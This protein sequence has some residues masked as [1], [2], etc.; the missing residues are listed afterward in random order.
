MLRTPR[1][2]LRYNRI[3]APG[4]DSDETSTGSADGDLTLTIAQ[5]GG[6]SPLEGGAQLGRYVVLE[7][8][9]A[10][11]MGEVVRAYDPKLRREVALKRLRTGALD[12]EAEARLLREAQAMAQLSHPN[13]LPVF[14]VEHTDEGVIMAMEFVDGQTLGQWLKTTPPRDELVRHFVAAGRALQAAHGAGLVHRDFKP[15]NVMRGN[16]GRVRVLDFGI[17]RA[18]SA[19]EVSTGGHRAVLEDDEDDSL[20][21]PLTQKGAV[22]GTPAY[23]APEQHMGQPA[24]ARS[25][26]Y[27]FCLALWE[28]LVGRRPFSGTM[29]E[30]V[31]AKRDGPPSLPPRA[32]VPAWLA[33][34]VVRGLQPEPDARWP[35]MAPLLDALSHD[36]VRARRRWAGL[37]AGAVGLVGAGA[38][39]SRVSSEAAPV[40]PDARTGLA[41]VWAQ[42]QRDQVSATLQE[43]DAPY[44][45]PVAAHVLSQIDDYAD[46]WVAMKQDTCEAT[47]IRGEQSAELFDLRV[48]CLQ[49]RHAGLGA[50]VS[51]LA[52]ADSEIVE[53][54]A[55]IVDGLP[56]LAPCADLDGLR[57]AVPPPETAQAAAEVDAIRQELARVDILT[58]AGRHEDA[59]AQLEPLVSRAKAVGYPLIEVEVLGA[60]GWNEDSA[61]HHAEAIKSLR[62]AYGTAVELGADR[63]AAKFAIDLAA[64][65]GLGESKLEPADVWVDAGM[66]L[67]RRTDDQLLYARALNVRG[68]IANRAA[69]YSDAA[70]DLERAIAILARNS[71]TGTMRARALNHLGISLDEL[72]Q[73]AEAQE[74]FREAA[75]LAEQAHGPE[76]PSVLNPLANLAISLSIEGRRGEA[77]PILE[78]VLAARIKLYGPA[79]PRTALSRVNLGWNY[80]DDGLAAESIDHFVTARAAFVEKLGP[81]HANVAMAAEGIGA[82]RMALGQLDAAAEAYEE[83]LAVRREALGPGHAYVAL[84]LRSLASVAKE[85]KDYKGALKTLDEALVLLDGSGDDG[86]RILADVHASRAATLFALERFGPAIASY[87]TALENMTEDV[88]PMKLGKTKFGLARALVASGGDRARARKLAELAHQTFD[89]SRDPERDEALAEIGT[90]LSELD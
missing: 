64:T 76:H 53:Q 24:D 55:K 60:H 33:S 57:A 2:G 54:A 71:G 81:R 19:V 43:S 6:T 11:G 89:A 42:T 47:R 18:T 85:R 28:G 90:F 69:R 36:P 41:D 29:T 80:M 83:S 9:G 3:L 50:V 84:S 48:S 49:R 66:A 7:R 72:E 73:F 32:K 79:H 13:V 22:M 12:P 86:R 20:S 78:R 38:L 34:I 61:G 63:L 40:C 87:E 10:G 52:E 26:Q 74:K 88:D 82:A 37:A 21:S 16:D 23:M 45:G 1:T 59:S 30:V 68:G 70:A 8:I 4:T 39:V 31:M 5:P 58:I 65:V 17:A 15:G 51:V 77:Q 27:A 44:A 56:A 14:D 25:D 46:R 35:T 75:T 67:A 62:E